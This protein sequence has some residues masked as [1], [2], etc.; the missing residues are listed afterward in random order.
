MHRS[1]CGRSLLED[2]VVASADLAGRGTVDLAEHAAEE[3]VI[4]EAVPFHDLHDRSVRGAQ[5]VIDVGEPH[6]IQVFFEGDADFLGEEP[7][8]IFVAE[9]EAVGDL[10]QR[11][12]FVIVFRDIGVDLTDAALVL[13]RFG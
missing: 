10:L 13:G 6:L 4:G 7:A 2:R 9:T 11:D 1:S 5:I 12:R 8:E 3:L